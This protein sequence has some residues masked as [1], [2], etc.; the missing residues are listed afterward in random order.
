MMPKK[1]R[2]ISRRFLLTKTWGDYSVENIAYL[3]AHYR[4]I[5]RNT[6]RVKK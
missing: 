6:K 2:T 4:A 5:R 3:K 1:K